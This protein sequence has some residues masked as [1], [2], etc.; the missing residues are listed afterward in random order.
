VVYLVE[1]DLR[2][3]HEIAA[4][5]ASLDMKTISFSS[6]DEYFS[7][8]REDKA[9]CIVAN[10][11][12][13]GVCGLELQRRLAQTSSLPVIFIGES[14]DVAS[15]VSAM[16]AGAFDLLTLP[17][18]WPA[19]TA[20]V[21]GALAQ[22]RKLRLRRAELSI[23]KGRLALLTPRERE[24]MPLVVSGLLNKQA[25]H[26]LGISEITLQIHRSQVMRKMQAESFA[27]L[28]RMAVKL[29]VPHWRESQSSNGEQLKTELFS[30]QNGFR[31]FAQGAAR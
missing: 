24:V 6:A 23:L 27:D 2:V 21:Q 17:L 9:G 28:V 1:Q 14:C 12:L 31:S 13:P 25:A 15:T 26:I 8:R 20:A 10:I 3:R 11:Q 16:K 30:L 19:L 7:F 5:L 22:D 29:R 18:N 4:H